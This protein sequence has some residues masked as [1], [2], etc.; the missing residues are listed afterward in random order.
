MGCTIDLAELFAAFVKDTGADPNAEFP[1]CWVELDDFVWEA[2]APDVGIARS[3]VASATEAYLLAFSPS[4]VGHLSGREAFVDVLIAVAG[5]SY[6]LDRD[7][8]L[9]SIETAVGNA[10]SEI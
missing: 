8:L 4:V 7:A 3:F 9:A 1:A 10:L 6:A 5:E 2:A